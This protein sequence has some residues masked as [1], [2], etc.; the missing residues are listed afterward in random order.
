MPVGEDC[1]T[2]GGACAALQTLVGAYKHLLWVRTKERGGHRAQVRATGNHL[3]LA[4]VS[5]EGRQDRPLLTAAVRRASFT[6][7]SSFTTGF[8]DLPLTEES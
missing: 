2:N 5:T 1:D 8:P 4:A 7:H 3:E 6:G